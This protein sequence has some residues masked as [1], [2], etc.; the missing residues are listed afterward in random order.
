M[1]AE[2]KAARRRG[3][4]MGL[5]LALDFPVTEEPPVTIARTSGQPSRHARN[6]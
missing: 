4:G 1:T 2:G 3:L 5:W 6:A